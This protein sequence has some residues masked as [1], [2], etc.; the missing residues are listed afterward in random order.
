MISVDRRRKHLGN[1]VSWSKACDLLF[2]LLSSNPELLR[3]A[4]RIQVTDPGRAK[5]RMKAS[6]QAYVTLEHSGKG[7]A[8]LSLVML[9]AASTERI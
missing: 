7:I 2:H 4:P 3:L 6:G 9:Q 5:I 1:H 8:L